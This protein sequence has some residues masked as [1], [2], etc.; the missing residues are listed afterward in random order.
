MVLSHRLDH[1]KPSPTMAITAKARL[2]REKGLDV[3][4]LSAGEPDF[5]TALSIKEKAIQ[6]IQEGHTLYTA[7]DGIAPLKKA[8]QE[9]FLRDNKLS[10]TLDEIMVSG[11]A[12]QAIFNAFFATLNAGD[13]VIIPAP[14]WVS[15]PAMV[16]LS[17]GIPV[18]ISCRQE[19]QFK[20]DPEHLRKHISERTKWLILN[21]PGNPT[22]SV[23]TK[24]ELDAL[25]SVLL[26][27]PHVHIL[28][29]DIYEHIL[30]TAE[31]FASLPQVV[32]ALKDRTL[33]INGVSK[34]YAMTGWRIGYAAGPKAIIK[35]M[36]KIQSQS[37]S[38]PC[39]ISQHAALEALSGNQS[40]VSA[41]SHIF[42]ERRDFVVARLNKIKGI[43]CL[44]P[45][46]AFYVFPSCEKLMG[47]KTKE[48]K[49]LQS[50]VDFCAYL[51]ERALVAVVPGEAFGFSSH[52]RLSYA[53]SKDVLEEAL[54]RMEEAILD[55]SPPSP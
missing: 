10:Y 18:L 12:K 31:P 16:T 52:F 17:G 19:H 41:Q 9:K 30:Y 49:S 54:E 33:C 3:L 28:S 14:Y 53:T 55:L 5:Q 48:G 47:F 20:L 32:P 2:L 22:G 24:E 11:G 26:D 27:F 51:L 25:G 42:Q 6:A 7:V 50:D 44:N 46:G 37:T 1:I 45:G 36:G 29:D 43:S 40:H 13:E 34:C 4:S 39:S 35:A 21:N 23:Y 38:S 15:Y 8:I